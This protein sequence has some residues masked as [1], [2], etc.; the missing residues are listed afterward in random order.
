MDDIYYKVTDYRNGHIFLAKVC[1]E[2][3]KGVRAYVLYTMG[4]NWQCPTRR[5]KEQ[6]IADAWK[7]WRKDAMKLNIS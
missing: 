7:T 1:Y 4:K 3:D 6:L 2:K 5:L